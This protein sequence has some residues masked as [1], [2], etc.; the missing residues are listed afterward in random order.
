[1]K[2]VARFEVGDLDG[3]D[4]LR[5]AVELG[6]QLGLGRD[7]ARAYINL[8]EL[9]FRHEGPAAALEANQVGR[10]VCE[11]RGI[12]DLALVFDG[13]AA[14]CL[15]DLGDWDHAMRLRGHS[16]TGMREG[17]GPVSS[18]CQR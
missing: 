6:L 1:M 16:G 8:S 13:E 11:E 4:D 9:L 7:T 18:R 10:K 15:I 5:Q 14:E 17:C 12:T 2:G 3:L